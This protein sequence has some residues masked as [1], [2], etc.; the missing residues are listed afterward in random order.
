MFHRDVVFSVNVSRTGYDTWH[1][2]SE[3]E[4]TGM[5]TLRD[6]TVS[7]AKTG[8]TIVCKAR[9]EL[10]ALVNFKRVPLDPWTPPSAFDLPDDNDG[11]VTR[12]GH[13]SLA[14]RSSYPQQVRETDQRKSNANTEFA[15]I[16]ASFGDDDDSRIIYLDTRAACTT[17]ALLRAGVRW[18]RL[19]SPQMDK[20]EYD[21]MYAKMGGDVVH[22]E[23]LGDTLRRF[24]ASGQRVLAL[25]ADYCCTWEGNADVCPR[26]DMHIARSL[27]SSVIFITLS[28]RAV[29]T[30]QEVEVGECLG[31]HWS[32]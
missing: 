2:V 19:V 4:K 1:V 17:F 7:H 13:R 18:Q 26:E 32:L 27:V 24:G 29:R 8:Y 31:G 22:H 9:S 16:V 23:A 21:V 3:D 11:P 28:R 14:P 12:K 5:F 20:D 25:F 30:D 6:P 10:F 15:R